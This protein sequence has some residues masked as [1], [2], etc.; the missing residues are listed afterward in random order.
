MKLPALIAA[1]ATFALA[2]T[3]AAAVPDAW[4]RA[5]DRL[6]MPVLYPT[7]HPGLAL[8]RVVPKEIDC[9]PI[10]E[11]LDGYYRG[12][13]GNRKRLRIA[14]GRPFYCGDI[15]DAGCSHTRRSM[16]GEPRSMS[17]A[18]ARAAGEQRT[19]TC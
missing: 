12:V 13:S 15:G 19:G 11:E 3:A 4:Q 9:G 16:A 17:T 8:N 14:E 5:A 6:D 10:E 2:S 7:H 1:V 18:R